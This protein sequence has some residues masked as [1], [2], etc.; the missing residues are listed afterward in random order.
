MKAKIIQLSLPTNQ[1]A[2]LGKKMWKIIFNDIDSLSL[3]KST[4]WLS[5]TS[6]NSQPNLHFPNLESAENFAK[7]HKM[8]YEVISKK[9][10]S[11]LKITYADNFK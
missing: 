9:P 1:N 3:D 6:T 11:S 5:T 2:P 8:L 4:G 10:R 7:E